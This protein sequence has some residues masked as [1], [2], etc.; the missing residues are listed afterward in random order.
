MALTGIRCTLGAT[1]GVTEATDAAGVI[2]ATEAA[3]M[4]EVTEA[5]G[6]IEATEVTEVTEAGGARGAGGMIEA[7][8]ITDG[9]TDATDAEGWRGARGAGATDADALRRSNSMKCVY[10]SR[11]EEN[12]IFV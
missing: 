12:C 5:A 8:G 9:G 1:G 3:G 10:E 4:T 2:E 11:T 6:V 7:A